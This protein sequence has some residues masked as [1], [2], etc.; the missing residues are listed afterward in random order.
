[1]SVKYEIGAIQLDEADSFGSG[2]NTV[3]GLAREFDADFDTIIGEDLKFALTVDAAVANGT[4]VWFRMRLD[5]TQGNPSDGRIWWAEKKTLNNALSQ[6]DKYTMTAILRRPKGA[7]R[8]KFTMQ[9]EAPANSVSGYTA[10]ATF[11]QVKR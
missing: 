10:S 4:N 2:I 1:M 8:V 5:G 9:C 3:E 7:H 11:R 6:R